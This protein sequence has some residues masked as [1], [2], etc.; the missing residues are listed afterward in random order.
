MQNPFT[1]IFGKSPLESIARFAQTNEII[2]FFSSEIVNQQIYMITGVRGAGKTVMLNDIAK[3]FSSEKDWIVLELNPDRNLLESFAAKL[4]DYKGMRDLFMKAQIDLSV[5][6]IGVSIE[7]A[8][9]FF[10]IEN[11]IE[12]MLEIVKKKKKRVLVTIDEATSNATMKVFASSFQIFVRRDFPLFLLMTGLFENIDALQNEKNLTF[13]YRAPKI[14]LNPLDKGA[15]KGKYQ[16]IF[17]LDD[18]KALEMADLTK[19]YPFAFQVLGYLTWQKNG[20]YKS[21]MNEYR[22]YLS[23]YVYDKIW[24]ELSNK[25]KK[26]C[27]GIAKSSDGRIKEIRNMLSLKTNEFNPYRDRLKKRGLID[28]EARGF[29][30]FMLPEFDKYVLI[31]Y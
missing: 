14:K 29:I 16:E 7:K 23:E 4:Y 24:S 31:H 3:H 1:L 17:S 26:I 5:L 27:Y 22:Q 12:A 15:V 13:L 8:E 6:G 10:D 9:P 11:A 20:D 2:D 18:E 30:R 19:G 21:V 25:D 28:T